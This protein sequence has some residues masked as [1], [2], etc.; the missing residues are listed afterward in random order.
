[1]ARN[2]GVGRKPRLL[3]GVALLVTICLLLSGTALYAHGGGT[4]RLTDAAAGPYRIF[5]WTQP[6]PLRVGEMHLSIG[7]VKAATDSV[8]SAETLDEA[9]TDATVIIHLLP[10]T[11]DGAAISVPAV[12]QEQLGSY[13][14]EADAALP[15]PG[16][17]C[18]TIEV[19]GALGAG[20]AEFVGTVATAREINW[21]LVA[22]AA[23]LLLCLLGLIG[24]WNRIQAKETI[25]DTHKTI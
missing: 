13:Y 9:V 22:A 11:E 2:A 14:Y 4:P 20:R 21:L 10:V 5:A 24:V 23:V 19:S 25:R 8:Q 1:M 7:V 12:L 18:F 16:E 3:W 6:E 15:T 17:W